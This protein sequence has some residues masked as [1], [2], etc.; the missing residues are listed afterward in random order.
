MRFLSSSLLFCGVAL[1]VLVAGTS[2][3]AQAQSVGAPDVRSLAP[4]AVHVEA[5]SEAEGEQQSVVLQ[6]TASESVAASDAW[7]SLAG[8]A[9]GRSQVVGATQ[10]PR[11]DMNGD[12]AP[13][14]RA[15][16]SAR[17]WLYVAGGAVLVGALTAVGVVLMGGDSE[18]TGGDRPASPPGRP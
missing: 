11:F 9:S 13:Q 1:A 8:R 15:D 3:L 6:R 7:K 14:S 2:T 4:S 17:N 10:P 12:G 5:D 18:N 16:N